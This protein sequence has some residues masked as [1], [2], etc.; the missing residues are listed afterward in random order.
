MFMKNV[1]QAT[2]SN[3]KRQ[4]RDKTRALGW[5]CCE[6]LLT[7]SPIFLSV[8]SSRMAVSCVVLFH[9]SETQ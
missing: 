9:A 7:R 6:A 3:K 2:E 1:S 5:N 8:S 4:V